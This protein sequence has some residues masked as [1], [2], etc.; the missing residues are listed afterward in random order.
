M[1]VTFVGKNITIR[2][3][4]KEETLKKIHRLDKYFTDD[5]NATVTMSTEGNHKRVEVTIPLPGT[6]TVLRADQSSFDMLQS[7]DQAVS[8]LVSQ[9][10]KFKTKLE[11][12][13]K[14]ARSIRFD[15]V[16]DLP[17]EA[18]SDENPEIARIKE[19]SLEPLTPEEAVDEMEMLG[20][21]F[22]LFYNSDQDQ[23]CCLYRRKVG[24]YG[25]LVPKK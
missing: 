10:R 24:N 12:R 5:V 23:V 4:F 18:Q 6:N 15:Q 13:H 14:A 20:H 22:Y 16:V 3:N 19:V 7:V 17:E 25:L 11:R 9:V 21:D 2:D 1:K 8:A